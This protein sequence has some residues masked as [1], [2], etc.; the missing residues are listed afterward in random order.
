MK[1]VDGVVLFLS[2]RPCPRGRLPSSLDIS[3]IVLF[4]DNNLPPR[5]LRFLVQHLFLDLM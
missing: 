5:V 3:R 1:P 2:C 4:H